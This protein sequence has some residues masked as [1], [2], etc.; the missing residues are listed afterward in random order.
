M[1]FHEKVVTD[2]SECV[3]RPEVRIISVIH[4]SIDSSSDD[5]FCSHELPERSRS[6]SRFPEADS[7]VSITHRLSERARHW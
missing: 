3:S 6:L 2:L 4:S 7:Y 5:K 1:Y